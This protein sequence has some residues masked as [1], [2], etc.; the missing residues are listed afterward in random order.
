[1]PFVVIVLYVSIALAIVM[2]L[3]GFIYGLACLEAEA[4]IYPGN[5]VIRQGVQ[6][7]RS[8]TSDVDD[9]MT[10]DAGTNSPHDTAASDDGAVA[11]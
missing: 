1:M 5:G 3:L 8:G 6:A 7:M 9:G 11:D 10:L 4:G 2:M